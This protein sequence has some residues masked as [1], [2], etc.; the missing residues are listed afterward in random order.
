MPQMTSAQA[1]VIDP[2]LTNVAR[3][4]KNNEFIGSNLFPTV[5]VGQRG[6]KIITFRKED[7][8]LYAT[9]RAPG[10]NTKRVQFGYDGSP[11]SLEQH[12]L[13]GQVPIELMEE[14]NAVPGINMATVAIRKV[15]NIIALRLE[16]YQADLALDPANYGP[17][18]TI[19]LAGAAQ[20][21]DLSSSGPIND[22]EVAKEA[23]RAATG[24]R[25]NVL[26]MGAA[27]MSALRLHTQI[28]DRIKYTGR[29]VPTNELLAQLFGVA[30]VV[31]GD[32][33]YTDGAGAF[34]DVWGKS[35]VLAYTDTSSL[36]DMGSPSFAYNYQLQSFPIV[37]VPYQDRNAKSWIYPVTDEVSPVIA[38]ADAGY[39]IQN[40]VA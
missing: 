18:N 6:G 13:E 36:A 21:S 29:D 15:Q 30:R 27:V 8:E 9:G 4:F 5:P 24:K 14:A 10:A 7:F 35:V 3:G 1:R 33:I 40:A 25:P 34:Q 39:L 22:V 31:S 19:P 26:V 12:A 23:I 20:W 38:G 2:I 17:N 11:Y 16:K 32:A 28:I 37:E